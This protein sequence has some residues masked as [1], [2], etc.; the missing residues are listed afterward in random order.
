MG[1]VEEKQLTKEDIVSL[2]SICTEQTKAKIARSKQFLE[3]AVKTTGAE[4][5][6]FQGQPAYKVAGL[7]RTY[8][9][10]ISTAKVYDYDTKKYRCIVNNRQYIGE[11]YDDVA[12]R[13]LALKNDSVMQRHITTLTGAGA[14]P[15][16]ENHY[17]VPERDPDRIIDAA[18]NSAFSR[19]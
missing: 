12:S 14:Q 3:T 13:L 5:I 8:A 1:K 19:A 11:G 15:G 2:L 9:V 7:L 10:I 6:E 4:L 17:N 18:I 16:A